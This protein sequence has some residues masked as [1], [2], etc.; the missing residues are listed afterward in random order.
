MS[1]SLIVDM[2]L[3]LTC[4]QAMIVS[5]VVWGC[6]WHQLNSYCEYEYGQ[7]FVTH[8][9]QHPQQSYSIQSKTCHRDIALA[10]HVLKGT[11]KL[12]Y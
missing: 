2:L 6:G 8:I 10:V 11:Y 7:S 4:H 3:S 5:L 12:Y 1:I 9:F